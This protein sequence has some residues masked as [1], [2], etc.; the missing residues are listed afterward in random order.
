MNVSCAAQV[1]PVGKL[2]PHRTKRETFLRASMKCTR[3]R[4]HCRARSCPGDVCLNHRARAAGI[5]FGQGQSDQ[6]EDAVSQSSIVWSTWVSC[7]RRRKAPADV[8]E[9]D[10]RRYVREKEA[11]PKK[12]PLGI[13][14]RVVRE[15]QQDLGWPMHG[16]IS[17]LSICYI[18]NPAE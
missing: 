5:Q 17:G 6:L 8:P 4:K 10:L 15:T 18:F 7:R 13:L 2:P 12:R 14:E 16:F 9:R 1:L 3:M 11:D